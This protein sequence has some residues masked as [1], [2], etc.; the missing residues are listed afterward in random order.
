MSL[1]QKAVGQICTNHRRRLQ[2]SGLNPASCGRDVTDYVQGKP[3]ARVDALLTEFEK[4]GPMTIADLDLHISDFFP[5]GEYHHIDV[6]LRGFKRLVL[7]RLL[8]PL[9]F[10][11]LERQTSYGPAGRQ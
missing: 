1:I 11:E 6:M 4:R 8:E 3:P 9:V 7:A 5:E 2:Q 10:D